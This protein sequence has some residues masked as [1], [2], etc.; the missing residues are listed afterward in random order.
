MG[1]E[2]EASDI[3]SLLFGLWFLVVLANWL[4]S[5]S[6]DWVHKLTRRSHGLC[7]V[8]SGIPIYMTFPPQMRRGSIG[9][10]RL[11]G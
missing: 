9:E 11:S 4:V 8:I 3:V 10:F 6:R 1:Y 5:H 7:T 2:L